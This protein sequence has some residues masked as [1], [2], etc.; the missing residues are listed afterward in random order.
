MAPVLRKALVTLLVAVPVVLAVRSADWPLVFDAALMHYAAW[1]ILDGARPYVDLFDMNFPGT[2]LFHM[3][4]LATLG[5]G[6]GAW[7]VVDL[8][9]LAATCAALAAF[10][11]P[12]GRLPAL[13]AA[14][15]Y[16]TYH[17]G[18]G[19]EAAG[20]R[21]YVFALPLVL[22]SLFAARFVE[23]DGRRV[24]EAAGFG[25]FAGL[26]A[27]IKPTA[28]L[29]VLG[30][31]PF[32]LRAG[33][34]TPAVLPRAVAAAIGAALLPLAVAVGWVVAQGSGEAFWGLVHEYL[35]LYGRIRHGLAPSRRM[36]LAVVTCLLAAGLA[37]RPQP[38]RARLGLA[39]VGSL[40]GLA[41]YGAQGK[42]WTYHLYP[43][44]VF[45]LLALA[46]ALGRPQ[47]PRWARLGALAVVTVGLS[48]MAVRLIPSKVAVNA[49]RVGQVETMEGA[50][51]AHVPPGGTV[52]ILDTTAGG[53]HALLR[54]H[55]RLP[56]PLLYDFHVLLDGD[57]PFVV[58][59][60]ARVLAAWEAHPPDAFLVAEAAYPEALSGYDRVQRF[61]ALAAFLDAGYDTA[62]VEGT[63]VLL[64]R[65]RP[66]HGEAP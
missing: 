55:S 21:D 65:A 33:L 48:A 6:D 27:T 42:F 10:A 30:A 18:D 5:E 40:V 22:S 35:P 45:G 32:L 62:V 64:T 47:D 24:A 2:Y 54:L 63:F 61:P 56:S 57:A 15:W 37:L 13:A 31:A 49:W 8:G 50:I 41:A 29:W 58:D 60:R 36:I 34:R 38:H 51:R 7:R 25:L 46:M 53:A 4:V 3:G 43:A 52:Q 14:S 26:A 1:S 12:V 59:L 66:S 11:W 44:V 19:P 23:A 28:V 17:L 20:Q 39:V 16:A 9:V